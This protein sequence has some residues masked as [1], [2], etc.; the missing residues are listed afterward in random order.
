MQRQ[1]FANWVKETQTVNDT[2]LK[3]IFRYEAH[4]RLN[5]FANTQNYWILELLLF[6]KKTAHPQNVTEGCELWNGGVIW[7][8]LFANESSEAVTLNGIRYC[9]MINNFLW[10]QLDDM[11]LKEMVSTKWLHITYNK[12]KKKISSS[13]LSD[14]KEYWR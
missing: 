12:R 9:G 3:N 13:W 4:F 1:H 5:G 7:R 8:L 11:E 14:L 10:D 6:V 2:F